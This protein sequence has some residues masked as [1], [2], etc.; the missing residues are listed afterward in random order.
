MDLVRVYTKR[1]GE[2]PDL[3]EPVVISNS[4]TGGCTVEHL[5]RQLHRNL[6]DDFNYAL[7]WGKSA[8]HAPQRVGLKHTLLDED[9]VQIV[10]R[11]TQQQRQNSDYAARCQESYDKYKER[12]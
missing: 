11:T 6:A 12:K 9:V 1:R 5:C 8:K 10:K 4:R 7:V 3:N 2:P